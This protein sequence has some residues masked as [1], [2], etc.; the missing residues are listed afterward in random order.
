MFEIET[1]CGIVVLGTKG[2]EKT[3]FVSWIDTE[4]THKNITHMKNKLFLS[5]YAS[6]ISIKSPGIK[7]SHDAI[8]GP[9][10]KIVL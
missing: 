9:E 5:P 10:L 8:F 4:S 6:E 7:R 2:A 1:Q 3:R